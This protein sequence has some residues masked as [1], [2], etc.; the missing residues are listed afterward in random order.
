MRLG[1]T[2]E[3]RLSLEALLEN[4]PDR[5]VP[6]LEGLLR[7]CKNYEDAVRVAREGF[8]VLPP[9]FLEAHPRASV[10][11]AQALNQAR[12]HSEL[13]E[14]TRTPH[15]ALS[16]PER[17][18]FMLYR[19]WALLQVQRYEEAL[20]LL[21]EIRGDLEP[22]HL[23]LWLRY[24]ASAL[25]R[26]NRPGWQQGFEAA[27]AH[28][29]GASLGRCL[30]EWAYHLHQEGHLAQ[31]R[32][33][34]AEALAY[35]EADPYYQAWAHH[36]LGIT[37]LHSRPE[38]AEHHLLQ[39]VE[40]SRRKEAAAFRAR[41]LCGLAA[42]RRVMGEWERALHSYRAAA[43]AA[44]EA[45]DRRE[46]HWGMGFTLRLMKRP[47]EA[48]AQFWQA[49]AAE[50]ADYLYVDIALAHLMLGDLESAEVALGQ[51]R[52]ID[53]KSAMKALLA[54]AELARQKGQPKTLAALLGEI[55]WQQP[56]IREEK[57]CL[58]ALFTLAEQQG[59]LEPQEPRKEALV[60][61]VQASGVLQVRVNG[62]EVPLSPTSRAAEILVLLLE[63]GGESTLDA[64]MDH[65]F[66]EETD[67]QKARRAIWPHL[68]RLREAL[69]WAQSVEARGGTYR[70]DPRA[71]WIYDLHDPQVRRRGKFLEGI[72]SNWVQERREELLCE[73][74]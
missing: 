46:A 18:Q 29:Q 9:A 14:L 20:G 15:P 31:A 36:S 25:A 49:H 13:L 42:T 21:E 70:L 10:L 34:W 55:D 24:R 72:F 37:V 65:L 43:K 54:R 2:E 19:S 56:W 74:E 35:L 58:E 67:R 4:H 7:S 44:S 40:L 63:H 48:L 57:P 27:R 69:G 68:G 22:S 47:S 33:L 61:E 17:A 51:A 39:A 50:P 11:Y 41:A 28:L 3:I 59:Y 38:E 60:V 45:D 12:M 64:L 30:I 32:S 8:A 52:Q 71:Q 6:F 53:R 73:L 66:P 16:P 1:R 5:V 62:R 26:L 23:G